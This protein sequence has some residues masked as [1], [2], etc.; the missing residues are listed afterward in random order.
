M[1]SFKDVP[2]REVVCHEKLGG[3]VVRF[4]AGFG[5]KARHEEQG[6]ACTCQVFSGNRDDTLLLRSWSLEGVFQVFPLT[7]LEAECALTTSF[8]TDRDEGEGRR[9][10]F[11]FREDH[12]RVPQPVASQT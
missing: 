12:A 2:G 6:V 9:C 1:T 5:P 3:V 11:L 4:W 10:A 8:T 7:Y